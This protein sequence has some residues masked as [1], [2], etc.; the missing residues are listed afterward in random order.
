MKGSGG[1][2]MNPQTLIRA[3]AAV[4]QRKAA[5]AACACVKSVL[6][7]GCFSSVSA[8]WTAFDLAE[9]R[10]RGEEG[11]GIGDLTE[12][13]IAASKVGTSCSVA[14]LASG[15]VA[16]AVSALARAVARSLEPTAAPNYHFFSAVTYSINAKVPLVKDDW[17]VSFTSA[18]SELAALIR[19]SV[20]CS[21]ADLWLEKQ[22]AKRTKA[23][24]P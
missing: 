7:L 19:E 15:S 6:H 21:E 5:I 16:F 11:V 8:V 17:D 1:K 20:D 3:V 4:N 22:A 2:E 10:S 12:A 18:L 14:D 13:S 23:G 9:R 24:K